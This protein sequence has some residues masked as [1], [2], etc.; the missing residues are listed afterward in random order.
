VEGDLAAGAAGSTVYLVDCGST[1][2]LAAVVLPAPVIDVA[3]SEGWAAALLQDSLVPISCPSGQVVEGAG[4]PEAGQAVV[5]SGGKA[6]VL[7]AGGTMVVFEE[8]SWTDPEIV[9]TGLEGASLICADSSGTALFLDRPA[10]STIVR[11][12]PVTW[13]VTSSVDVYG[14]V[15]DLETAADGFCCAMEG[16]NE[17]WVMG[18][19]CQVL[20]LLTYPA[21]PACGAAMPDNSYFYAGCPGVGLV[22]CSTSGEQVLLDQSFPG[23]VDISLGEDFAFLASAADSMFYLLER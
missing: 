3:L 9:K 23:L 6:Y 16:S 7:C 12:D 14:E 15:V 18:P 2:L 4:L 20:F 19:Q 21:I 1:D 5:A 22:V 17:I 8:G 13:Q 10:D 11:I